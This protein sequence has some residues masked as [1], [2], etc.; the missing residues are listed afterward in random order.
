MVP[1]FRPGDWLWIRTPFA[2]GVRRGAVVLLRRTKPTAGLSLKR[3]VGLPGEHLKLQGASLSI[4]GQ[5]HPEP[6]VDSRS[7]LEPKKDAA[8]DLADQEYVVLGDVRDDSL[9]SRAF[10]PVRAPQIIGVVA[11]RLWPPWRFAKF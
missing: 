5:P 9:D 11:Y 8:W 1:A 10:G 6:Y 4:N 3:I 7:G 2:S